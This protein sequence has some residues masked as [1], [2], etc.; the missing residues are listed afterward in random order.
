[1]LRMLQ[2]C[3]M[4]PHVAVAACLCAAILLVVPAQA[5]SQKP[6]YIIYNDTECMTPVHL[7][8]PS[9]LEV[10]YLTHP[11]YPYPEFSEHGMSTACYRKH[12]AT[13]EIK[14]GQLSLLKLERR[15]VGDPWYA[16][17]TMPA[18]LER[19]RNWDGRIP[20]DWFTGYVFIE[21]LPGRSMPP[22]EGVAEYDF[23]VAKIEQGQVAGE[24]E[25]RFA[26]LRDTYPADSLYAAYVTWL[27]TAR[28]EQDKQLPPAAL[29]MHRAW[30]L[31]MPWVIAT[32]GG[33]LLAG[34]AVIIWR[35]RI[36]WQRQA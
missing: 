4:A 16:L 2:S 7:F 14:D 8:Y 12:I 10:F 18:E 20:M 6:D 26:D 30:R 9:L 1:M 31:R 29:G 34:I 24:E 35:R 5:T 17:M 28:K 23:V 21:A 25:Y 32:V 22:R 36:R 27:E 3:N 11:E 33:L 19:L 15:I 13:W